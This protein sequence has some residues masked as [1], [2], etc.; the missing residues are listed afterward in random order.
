L[1]LYFPRVVHNKTQYFLVQQWSKQLD[2]PHIRPQGS[3]VAHSFSA[4]KDG[5]Y[6]A[7]SPLKP[8][9]LLLQLAPLLQLRQHVDVL[10]V[11]M[12][13]APFAQ[14][15]SKVGVD[16]ALSEHVHEEVV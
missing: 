10:A 5:S 16:A 1:I 9:K 12:R 8:K 15:V 13:T 11:L 6:I 7:A 4:L 2:L 14:L 3:F